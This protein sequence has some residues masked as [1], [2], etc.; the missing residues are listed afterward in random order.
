MPS[1]LKRVGL[2][3][4]RR[5][6][7]HGFPATTK[8]AVTEQH[9]ALINGQDLYILDAKTG[10]ILEHRRIIGGPGGGPGDRGKYRFCPADERSRE[11]VHV[12]PEGPLVALNVSLSRERG[13][14]AN[15]VAG[16]VAWGNDAG[17]ISVIEP[18][19]RGILYRLRLT[20]SIAGPL[21]ALTTQA[22]SG[23]DSDRLTCTVST[24]PRG[25]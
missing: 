13:I 8:P 16:H 19:K 20:D 11:C 7:I 17:D 23:R 4:P 18:G 5:S 10:A 22:D 21:I 2:V 25:D 12:W 24:S 9:L 1:M 14:S 3:G 15:S 6:A